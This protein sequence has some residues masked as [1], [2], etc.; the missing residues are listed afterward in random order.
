LAYSGGLASTAAIS[1][2]QDRHAVEV[3]AVV[4]GIGQRGELAGIREQALSSGALRCHVLDVEAAF[5]R[6][7]LWPI[8]RAGVDATLPPT[9]LA[10][11]LVA[12]AMTQIAR[13]EQAGAVAH[14][15]AGWDATRLESAV[16]DL[17]PTLA[18][19]PAVTA[20]FGSRPALESYLEARGQS[21]CGHAPLRSE[22][23]LWGRRI[24]GS[25]LQDA[26]QAP[27]PNALRPTR[28]AGAPGN[29]AV[30]ELTFDRGWPVAV[31]GVSMPLVE[32]LDSVGT[33]AGAQG[34]GRADLVVS[35]A[36][37]RPRREIHETPA[38]TVLRQAHAA[39]TE[40]I[41]PRGADG[42]A[43]FAAGEYASVLRDGRW[44]APARLALDAYVDTT[45]KSVTGSATL[46]LSAFACRV[47][48]RRLE[49]YD[50]QAASA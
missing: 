3:V 2:L 1:W 27:P 26:A 29:G 17:D 11:P 38:L 35:D 20:Q 49:R 5:A 15:A 23:S 24:C 46:A 50:A 32:I 8:A 10:A 33:I 25:A 31:N 39:I 22:V 4:L 13:M 41:V 12:R 9:W 45:Q 14:G 34:I 7:L 21:S 19:A 37:G 44:Y 36:F 18:V 16:R 40:L 28:T 42:F 30:L 47:I 6:D 48:G 43:P